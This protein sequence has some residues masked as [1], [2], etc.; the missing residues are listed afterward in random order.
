M[1]TNQ[2]KL[3]KLNNVITKSIDAQNSEEAE[4]ELHQ[5]LLDDCNGVLYRYM[6]FC[7]Y[8]IPTIKEKTLHFS[9]PVV[10]NDPFDCKIGLD[11][12]SICEAL[13]SE[14][15]GY[16]EV[17]F[18]DFLALQ[19]G[20][21]A[22]EDIPKD[23][24]NIIEQW[25][26][27]EKLMELIHKT[28]LLLMS[29]NE[30]GAFIIENFNIVMEIVAPMIDKIASKYGFNLKDLM[31]PQ[32]LENMTDESKMQLLQEDS[33]YIDYVKGFG[34][35]ADADEID[36]TEMVCEKLQPE[37][38]ERLVKQQDAFK[39]IEQG[40][41]EELYNLFKVCC[42]STSNKNRLMWSHYAD[43]HKGI[44]IEYDFSEC[45]KNGNQPF[46]VYYSNAR[47]KFPWKAAIEQTPEMQREATVHFMKAL[48][49]K[50]EAWS[51]ER[52][53]RILILA[54]SGIDNIS[55]PPI[56]CIYIGALCSQGNA[57]KVISAAK[58]MG[59]PVKKMTVDRGE[60]ELHASDI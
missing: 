26:N 23:R 57:E 25:E 18:E 10:F 58:E 27:S 38:K 52:E 33:T 6:P 60:Y 19:K 7:D 12:I 8:T 43:S 20:E 39:I 28:G 30:K 50:D 31:I 54:N 37:N 13:F 49:T 3:E 56:K 51:Y 36:R 21:K 9:S 29:D 4:V 44:C 40:L 22:L 41:N 16:L 34:I 14:D 35:N 45:S 11:Y 32:L 1:I 15:F 55:A 59:I 48:L 17:C 46:P 42:L 2:E 53:W 47:P 5:M 24:F